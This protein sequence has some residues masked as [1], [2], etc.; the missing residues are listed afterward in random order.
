M[1]LAALVLQHGVETVELL[2]P[3]VN[4]PLRLVGHPMA[5]SLPIAGRPSSS[6]SQTT[7]AALKTTVI[8]YFT[9]Q[10]LISLMH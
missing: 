8:L 2:P 4:P 10:G 3:P 6:L 1:V 5:R 9:Y 7:L